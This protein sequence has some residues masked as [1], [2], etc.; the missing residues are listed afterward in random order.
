MSAVPVLTAGPLQWTFPG[1]GLS[2]SDDPVQPV[3][4]GRFRNGAGTGWRQPAAG[5]GRTQG[6]GLHFNKFHFLHF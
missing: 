5:A 2:G 1:L 4:L 6:E 3:T